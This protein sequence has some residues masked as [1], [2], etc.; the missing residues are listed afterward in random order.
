MKG[1]V[2]LKRIVRRSGDLANG[3]I[4]LEAA[5]WKDKECKLEEIL[6]LV[7]RIKQLLKKL[8]E[9]WENNAKK[10][11]KGRLTK[12]DCDKEENLAK[13]IGKLIELYNKKI[14]EFNSLRNGEAKESSKKLKFSDN[15][16]CCRHKISFEVTGEDRNAQ[17][18]D[19]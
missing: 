18:V 4:N 11:K 13:E 19:V 7:R 6:D 16:E 15:F 12:N 10:L 1:Y 3:S 9:T 5:I 8:D 17:V 2:R 14:S